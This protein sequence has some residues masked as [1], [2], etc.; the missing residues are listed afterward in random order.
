MAP[1]DG[2]RKEPRLGSRVI[3]PPFKC[4]PGVLQSSKSCPTH[5]LNRLRTQEEHR[6]PTP[7]TLHVLLSMNGPQ[8]TGDAQTHRSECHT[9]CDLLP[10]FTTESAL[11]AASK[12]DTHPGQG[13]DQNSSSNH[14]QKQKEQNPK[15]R[16]TLQDRIECVP[17]RHP[18][19]PG[20]I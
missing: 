13:P 16:G 11:W 17:N 4:L 12:T 2:A 1:C 15:I 6:P 9:P 19:L 3:C 14:C 8:G 7:G 18:P 10:T 5:N 20:T